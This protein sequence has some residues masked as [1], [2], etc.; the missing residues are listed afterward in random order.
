MKR[1]LINQQHCLDF[2]YYLY[3][4]DIVHKIMILHNLCMIL[5]QATTK[6]LLHS[7]VIQVQM[8]YTWHWLSFP[9]DNTAQLIW[10]MDYSYYK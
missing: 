8:S 2:N 9:N 10:E 6:I 1:K 4:D 7:A 3:I 5:K